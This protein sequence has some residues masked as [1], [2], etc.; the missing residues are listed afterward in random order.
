LHYLHNFLGL[1]RFVA[2]ANVPV[3]RGKH[4]LIVDFTTT[5]RFKG[6]V[7]LFYDDLPV[8]SAEIPMTVPFFYGTA[9]F[10]VGYLRGHSVIEEEHAPFAFTPGALLTVAVEPEGSTW[11]DPAREDR[12]ARATQ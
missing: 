10:T 11:R 7:E 8:G 2:A 12:A 5:G 1:R 9:G 3:P 6:T 4:Q